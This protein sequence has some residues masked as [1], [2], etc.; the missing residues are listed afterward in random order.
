[1][2]QLLNGLVRVE[3]V[4]QQFSQLDIENRCEDGQT[5]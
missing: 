5:D 4:W 1:M 2:L 3:L